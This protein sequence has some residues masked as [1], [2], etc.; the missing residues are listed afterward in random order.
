M[1]AGKNQA[2][3]LERRYNKEKR[4]GENSPR[5]LCFQN[6]DYERA[7]GFFAAA[8]RIVVST[9][10]GTCSNVSGSIE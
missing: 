10:F 1:T 9:L 8:S 7:A 5:R 4:R 2:A 3:L 6:F